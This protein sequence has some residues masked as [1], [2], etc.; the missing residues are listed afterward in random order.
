MIRGIYKSRRGYWIFKTYKNKI[1][2]L[3]AKRA[4]KRLGFNLRMTRKSRRRYF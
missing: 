3:R 4:L 2:F 1:S